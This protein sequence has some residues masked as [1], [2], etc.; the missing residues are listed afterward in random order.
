ML[1]S[2]VLIALGGDGDDSG[3]DNREGGLIEI[4]AISFAVLSGLSFVA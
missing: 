4:A 3:N 2:L 1:A